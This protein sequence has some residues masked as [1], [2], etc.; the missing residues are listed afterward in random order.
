[1]GVIDWAQTVRLRNIDNG[2]TA[3]RAPAKSHCSR[4]GSGIC[5]AAHVPSSTRARIFTNATP[6]ENA[7]GVSSPSHTNGLKIHRLR[8]GFGT[9]PLDIIPIQGQVSADQG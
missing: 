3:A 5:T 9:P 4:S 2:F 6:W 1:K 7:N 8:P